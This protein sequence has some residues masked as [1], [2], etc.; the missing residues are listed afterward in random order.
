MMARR[1]RSD[2]RGSALVEFAFVAPVLLFMLLGLIETGRL[3]WTRHSLDEVAYT[4]VRCMSVSSDCAT[5]ATRKGLAVDR[6][7]ALGLNVLG[8]NVT[9][10]ENTTCKGLPSA[11]RVT[12]TM[13][14]SSVLSGFVPMPTSLSSEACFPRLE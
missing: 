8:A 3:L 4:T 12:I 5:E 9:P 1:L 6:A 2:Q 14:Y 10:Q 13:A 7:A 11:N